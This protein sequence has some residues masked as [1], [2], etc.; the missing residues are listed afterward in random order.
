MFERDP[1]LVAFYHST[2]WEATRAAFMAARMH[3]CERCGRPAKIVHHKRHL[4]A[5]SV[6]DPSVALSFKNL[7]ALCQECHN[8]EHFGTSATA[9]GLRF[10]KDGNLIAIDN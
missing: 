2:V 8:R 10:D 1:A 6:G 5:K 4:D 3:A 9:E 7:E